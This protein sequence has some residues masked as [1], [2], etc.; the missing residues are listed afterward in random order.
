[1]PI[2]DD[3]AIIDYS[4]GDLIQMIGGIIS[5]RGLAFTNSGEFLFITGYDSGEI[6]KIN[7]S[8]WEREGRIFKKRAAMRHAVVTSD[9]STLFVSDMLHREIYEIKTDTFTVTHLYKIPAYPNPNTID[10]SGY[11]KLLFVSSRGPNNPVD[12]TLRSP[13]DGKILVFNT[14]TKELLTIIKG[15]NQ[16]TGLDVSNDGNILAFSNFLDNTIELYDISRINRIY[17]TWPLLA[18]K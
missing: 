17:A 12:Y 11:G 1:M 3:V 18:K 5:P 13:E 15:G 8:N 7:T 14:V 2:Q 6:L 10:I 4:T 9:D 16:P